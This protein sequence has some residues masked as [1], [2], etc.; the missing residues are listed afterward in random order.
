[1]KKNLVIAFL[2]SAA[3]LTGTVAVAAE[4]RCV[5]VHGQCSNA[6]FQ[7]APQNVVDALKRRYPDMHSHEVDMSIAS[8]PP[9]IFFYA[10]S[11]HMSC[12]VDVGPPV[13]LGRC[14]QIRA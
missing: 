3:C 13:R 12:H 7:A 1:M 8:K 10:P 14:H 2:T 9:E 5:R 6:C 11:A 4:E